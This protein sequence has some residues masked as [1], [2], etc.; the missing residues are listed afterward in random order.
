MER[1]EVASLC[2]M[3]SS[4]T[5]IKASSSTVST[6]CGKSTIAHEEPATLSIAERKKMFEKPLSCE[7]EA[8]PGPLS[9]VEAPHRSVMVHFRGAFSGHPFYGSFL[10]WRQRPLFCL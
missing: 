2:M 5:P 4:D 9:K 8:T 6:P 7:E 1:L 3:V 10:G